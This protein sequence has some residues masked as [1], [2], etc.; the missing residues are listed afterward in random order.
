MPHLL[1]PRSRATLSLLCLLW[2]CGA[3]PEQQLEQARA[4]LA[5]GDW[6][7][8]AA[9]ASQGLA[10]GAEGSTA[11]RLELAALEG[12]ARGGKTSEVL[13]R[14]E[15]L[16][17]AWSSQVNGAL[18][19]QTAGQ[20]KEAGDAAGAIGVLDAGARRFPDDADIARAIGQLQAGGSDEEIE[21]LRSLGYVE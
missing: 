3:G 4:H 10:A 19:V 16:A 2:A 18:Y 11:W 17:G 14:L 9:A 15:R 20:V 13:A 6:A 21:R 5:S 1:R 12:E 8:A 7:A